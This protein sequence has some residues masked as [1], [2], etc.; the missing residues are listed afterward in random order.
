MRL[1]GYFSDQTNVYLIIE[2]CPGGQL[3]DL[4]RVKGRLREEEWVPIMKGISE[5]LYVLHL[6]DV[7]HR[8]LKP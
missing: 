8:D 6:H 2:Y 4:F 5:G 1:Y 7:I 3:Y